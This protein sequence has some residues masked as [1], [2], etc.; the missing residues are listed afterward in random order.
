MSAASPV[1]QEGLEV[2]TLNLTRN[3][4]AGK[5]RH[6]RSQRRTRD[7]NDQIMGGG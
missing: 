1:F 2:L 4:I 5:W 7:L 3:L 6:G